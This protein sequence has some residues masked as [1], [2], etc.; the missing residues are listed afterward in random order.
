MTIHPF[1]DGPGELEI[2]QYCCVT[3]LHRPSTCPP[4]PPGKSV[5]SPK[6]TDVVSRLHK[7]SHSKSLCKARRAPG[8][9]IQ[10]LADISGVIW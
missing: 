2:E 6:D 5:L 10:E 4:L 1:V 9:H 8:R 7:V 3:V